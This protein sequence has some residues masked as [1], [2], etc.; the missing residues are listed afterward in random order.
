MIIETDVSNEYDNS[1]HIKLWMSEVPL[2]IVQVSKNHLAFPHTKKTVFVPYIVAFA[3]GP[4][5]FE[6]AGLNSA[7]WENNN[8]SSKVF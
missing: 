3:L 5:T 7:P 6:N 8:R 1:T 4:C 2:K